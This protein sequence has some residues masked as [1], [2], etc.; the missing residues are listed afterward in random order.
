MNS[1]LYVRARSSR[2]SQDGQN[3]ESM[4]NEA[5]VIQVG[6]TH[7][8]EASSPVNARYES[9]SATKLSDSPAA[10]FKRTIAITSSTLQ[11]K[12]SRYVHSSRRQI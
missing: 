1:T 10:H 4:S 6:T 2:N 7:Q 5:N 9:V 11:F 12:R 8:C 3:K